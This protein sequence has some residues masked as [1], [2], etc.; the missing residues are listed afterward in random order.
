MSLSSLENRS[1]FYLNLPSNS[2]LP[3]GGKNRNSLSHFHIML[4]DKIHLQGKWEVGL[5]EIFIPSYG[6]NM[7]LPL[8]SSIKIFMKGGLDPQGVRRSLRVHVPEGRYQPKDFIKM[9]N[10]EVERTSEEGKVKSRLHYDPYSN[11]IHFSIASGEVMEVDNPWLH[12]MLGMRRR[13]TSFS[14]S[15]GMPK[16]LFVMPKTCEFNVNG[17][18]MFVYSNIVE[19][20]PVGNAMALI[21][22]TV[23][24]EL[25][26][27]MQTLN[28]KY[29]AI[30]YFPVHMSVLDMI[31]VHLAN[32]YGEDMEFYGGESS[33]I[34]HFRK[35]AEEK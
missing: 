5:A 23:H 2:P 30:H 10:T 31:E 19:S 25:D 28:R 15:G 12:K 32:V 29:T 7:K 18:M 13:T 3:A 1:N 11:R 4:P 8:T 14:N 20:S 16:K 24:L 17:T 26:G 9:F 33:L 22:H 35:V 27:T 34:V 6:F 21:M